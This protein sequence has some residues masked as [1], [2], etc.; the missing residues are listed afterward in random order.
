M[1]GKRRPD[2]PLYVLTSRGSFSAAE[3][4]A[5]TLKNLKRATIVGQTT[6]GGAHATRRMKINKHFNLGVPYAKASDPVTGETWEG[7]GVQPDVTVQAHDALQHAHKLAQTAAATYRKSKHQPL[8]AAAAKLNEQ[9]IEADKL[10]RIN[11]LHQAQAL[12][13]EALGQVI[14]NK[15]GGEFEINVVGSYL[16]QQQKPALAILLLQYNVAAFVESVSAL[17][18]LAE[19]Y[20]AEGKNALAKQYYLKILKLEPGNDIATAM[21]KMLQ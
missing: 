21:L 5:F 7:V 6:S 19:A 9:L 3:A 12:I 8:I 1:E 4:L 16:Q 10:I 18:H 2:L 15:V 11:Q 20:R 13:N 14:Q 17:Y